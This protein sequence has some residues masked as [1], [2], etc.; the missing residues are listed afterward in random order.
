MSDEA[1]P[2]W[3]CVLTDLRHDVADVQGMDDFQLEAV[4]DCLEE[5][6]DVPEGLDAAGLGVDYEM[7]LAIDWFADLVQE[8]DAGHAGKAEAALLLDQHDQDHKL[9]ARVWPGLV[10]VCF[11]VVPKFAAVVRG[12]MDHSALES[13]VEGAL[14]ESER[15]GVVKL[16]NH[17][18]LA[19]EYWDRRYSHVLDL[20]HHL[21]LEPLHLRPSQLSANACCHDQLSHLYYASRPVVSLAFV[22]LG[23]ETQQHDEVKSPVNQHPQSFRHFVHAEVEQGATAVPVA[24]DLNSG[25]V[26]AARSHQA[27]VHSVACY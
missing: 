24:A 10:L 23:Q 6:C 25:V 26:A 11:V 2:E 8:A 7:Q 22:P 27:P 12:R 14:D 20:R 16:T 15:V 5:G 3:H 21:L 18:A 4:S 1:E 13:H 19:S 9:E 17:L